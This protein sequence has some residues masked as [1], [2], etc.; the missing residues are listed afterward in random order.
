MCVLLRL[1]AFGILPNVGHPNHPESGDG[2]TLQGNK[3]I[4][5]RVSLHLEIPVPAK[6]GCDAPLL[7]LN[8]T[9]CHMNLLHNGSTPGAKDV[10]LR[11]RRRRSIRETR[12]E[13]KVYPRPPAL[14]PG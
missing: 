3:A 9:E 2:H 14:C 6:D 8:I 13:R 10:G 4:E 5:F 7:L 12:V 11:H 1:P